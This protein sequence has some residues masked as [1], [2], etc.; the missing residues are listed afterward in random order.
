MPADK[1][2]K[3][4]SVFY[5]YA[6]EDTK[7]VDRLRKHLSVLR[8]NGTIHEW[9][10][11]EILAGEDWKSSINEHLY[12]ADMIIQLVTKD[13]INSQ[14]CWSKEMKVARERDQ[15]GEAWVIAVIVGFVDIN[16]A[17]FDERQL[18]PESK[19]PI[20]DWKPVDKGWLNVAMAI[21][22]VLEEGI[23]K[24]KNAP[25]KSSPVRQVKTVFGK[26]QLKTPPALTGKKQPADKTE[27]KAPEV[28]QLSSGKSTKLSTIGNIPQVKY[29]GLKRLI[30]D[31]GGKELLPG[32][33]VR[34][35][36]D[37]AV[38]D[39]AVNE[40]YERLGLCYRFFKE[41]YDRDSYDG[42]GAEL[43]ATIHYGKK[44]SNAF[45]TGKKAVFGDGDKDL[46]TRMTVSLDA[47]AK[48]FC[49]AV[50]SCTQLEYGNH[51]GTIMN[52]SSLIL[53]MLVR[54][55]F[56]HQLVNQADW[57]WGRD[58]TTGRLRGKALYSF[59]APGTAYKKDPYWGD[60]PQPSHMR[61][62]VKTTSDYGGIHINSGILQHAFYLAAM[63]IGG[64][65]WEKTGRIW[66]ESLFDKRIR[67]KT[68][69][70]E[71]AII[72]VSVATRLYGTAGNEAEAFRIAWREVGINTEKRKGAATK[73]VI[74]VRR[75]TGNKKNM[76]KKKISKPKRPGRIFKRR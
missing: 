48:Q 56:L 64:Y 54:H 41:I 8:Q 47:V 7:Q 28:N 70:Q 20:A 18:V 42:K 17:G 76:V 6:H 68:D 40:V 2:K 1:S 14:Y 52:A 15:K 16:G 30:Y 21:R 44:F 67:K 26:P 24:K 53:S 65:A 69:F 32:K 71:F 57:G 51:P 10:D 35:E 13:F 45:W 61:G 55:H 63:K 62:F 25:G 11:R 74:P 73:K 72:T 60:D 33:P 29:P 37:Q 4:Y 43:Q 38:K 50:L 34:K 66:Y 23:R 9:Y 75:S 5:S 36:T 58:L 27:T 31:A 19:K 59:S 12:K 3:T 46:L 49:N 22:R 39:N